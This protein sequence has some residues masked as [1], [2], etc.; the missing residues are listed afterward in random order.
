VVRD[1]LKLVQGDL[2]GRRVELRTELARD[3]SAIAGDRVQLQQVLINLV[4]NACTAMADTGPNE[5]RIVVRTE[6]LPGHGARV[7][8]ADRGCGIPEGNLAR[9][10]EP[11]FT[12]GPEG[13]G[14]GLAVCRTIITAHRGRLWAENNPDRGAS[15][16]FTL[17]EAEEVR[18]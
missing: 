5:R 18:S 8:V 16:R 13:M 3:V 12:T 4:A 17:P 10:F 14:L 2:L 1:G 7:T 15:V 9:I 11:F 6:F